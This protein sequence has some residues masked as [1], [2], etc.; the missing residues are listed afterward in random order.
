M[1]ILK[2]K[3]LCAQRWLRNNFM[4]I[5]VILISYQESYFTHSWVATTTQDGGRSTTS[6]R[7]PHLQPYHSF[8]PDVLQW[9]FTQSLTALFSKHPLWLCH[10]GICQLSN[11][12]QLFTG[13]SITPPVQAFL[14]R[15]WQRLPEGSI[16]VGERNWKVTG[17]NTFF[18]PPKWDR[19][20]Q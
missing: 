10:G 5:R 9:M 2:A 17:G 8:S 20:K 15:L 1:Q 18:L 19:I 3:T 13:W 6:E 7:G 14:N 4:D 12:L 11:N 16:K